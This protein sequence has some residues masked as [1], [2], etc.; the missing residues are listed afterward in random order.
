VPLGQLLIESN[1]VDSA[2]ID[3]A[4]QHQ[5]VAGGTLV[6][7]LLELDLV[8]AGELEAFLGQAPPEQDE[9]E[10]TGLGFQ[11]LLGFITKAV[12]LTGLETVPDLS[13]YTKLSPV[14]VQEVLEDAKQKH[15]VD[16]LG[17][18]DSRRSIYRYALTDAGRRWASDAIE[19][20]TYSGPAPVTLDVWQRQVLKQS[21][22]RDHASPESISASL[23]HLVLDPNIVR[24]IGPAVDSG[25]AILLYGEVGNGKSS[26][27]EAVGNAYRQEIF[28]PY[29]VEID[30]QIIKLFDAAVHHE[31]EP[32]PRQDPRW[33]RCQRPVVTTGGELTIEMLDLSFDAVTKT[34]EAPAHIKATG[35]VFI[36]DD[37]GRQ[38]V[39]PAELLNRWMIPLERRVDYLTLHTGKKLKVHF[40][41]LLVISTN[42]PPSQLIDGAGLRRIPYK[43]ELR[44]PTTDDY[45]VIF[46]RTCEAHGLQPPDDVL[47]YLLEEFYPATGLELSGAHPRFLLDHVFERCRYEDRA[48]QIDLDHVFDAVHSLVVEERP[49]RPKALGAS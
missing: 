7:S 19:Q 3:E 14:V 42:T 16:V 41:E 49:P 32:S 20:C 5:K 33:V 10:G 48:L 40:D 39:S 25:R 17:L 9:I 38:R 6:D 26:I 44:A 37:F 46:R 24:R 13:D 4:R 34:Y 18:A 47:R 12:Y 8:D 21:I 29:C 30:G 31:V 27:A 1:V 11:F 43:M 23:S 45:A 28:I 36:L 35:G 22:A 15:L 2:G